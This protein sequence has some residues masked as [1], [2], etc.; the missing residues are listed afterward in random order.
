VEVVDIMSMTVVKPAVLHK[1]LHVKDGQLT[2]PA[3]D[4]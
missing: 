2:Y 1:H 3:V 4:R